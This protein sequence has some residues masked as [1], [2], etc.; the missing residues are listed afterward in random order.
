ML[1]P[2][3]ADQL[4]RLA[5]A[6]GATGL[7]DEIDPRLARRARMLVHSA[8][9]TEVPASI[10]ASLESKGQVSGAVT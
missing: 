6:L 10:S 4:A 7:T 2:L 8:S 3:P 9:S 1:R 5:L